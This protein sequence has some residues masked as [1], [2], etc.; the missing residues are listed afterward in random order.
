MK[1]GGIPGVMILNDESQWEQPRTKKSDCISNSPPQP[2]QVTPIKKP[3][4]LL[5][6]V[7]VAYWLATLAAE[8]GSGNQLRRAVRTL[9]FAV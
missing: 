2:G 6:A 4:L 7:I 9:R 1:A 5:L 3:L 8:F